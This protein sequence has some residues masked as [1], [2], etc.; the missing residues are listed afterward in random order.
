[1][2]EKI[3]FGMI[4]VVLVISL[5]SVAFAAPTHPTFG[6][7][8]NSGNVPSGSILVLDITHKVTNDEDS[9]NV[10]YWALDNYNKHVQVWQAPDGTFYAV[11]IVNDIS[12]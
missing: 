3:L 5:A 10:G 11:A 9:G 12:F 6:S 1:M 4:V 2:K 8:V 7:F